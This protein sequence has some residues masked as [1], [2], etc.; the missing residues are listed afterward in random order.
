M[1]ASAT[2]LEPCNSQAL[3]F[4]SPA[5][6]GGSGRGRENFAALCCYPPPDQLRCIADACIGVLNFR[7]GV[8]RTPMPPPQAGEVKRVA[9]SSL[10]IQ[11]VKQPR[12]IGPCCWQATGAPVFSSSLIPR[13]RS[14]ERRINNFHACEARRASLRDT[15]ASRRSTAAI[16]ADGTAP[17][18]TRTDLSAS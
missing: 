8:R 14:A 6:G 13:E 3:S 9:S 18:T 4:P 16:L 15:L 5:C 12:V 7:N 11:S 10:P 17:M 1:H 2:R